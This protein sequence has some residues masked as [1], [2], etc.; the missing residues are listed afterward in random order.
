MAFVK[1]TYSNWPNEDGSFWRAQEVN[2]LEGRIESAFDE[3]GSGLDPD[4]EAALAGTDGTPSDTNRFVTESD[5][6]SHEQSTSA[7]GAVHDAGSGSSG[8]RY[9]SPGGTVG[10][11]SYA[12]AVGDDSRATNGGTTGLGAGTRTGTNG[13]AVGAQASAGSSGVAVG[14]SAAASGSGNPVAI[15]RDAEADAD[16]RIVLRANEVIQK[17]TSGG[18]VMVSTDGG[19]SFTDLVAD[20][21]ARLSDARTPTSHSHAI[22]DV[23]NLQSSLDGKAAASHS[24]APSAITGGTDGQVLT[25]VSGAATWAD[26]AGGGGGGPEWHYIGDPGEP[27]FDEDYGYTTG[28]LRYS[29]DADG[30]VTWEGAVSLDSSLDTYVLSSSTPVPI[31]FRPA[32]EVT[33]FQQWVRAGGTSS[34][35]LSVRLYITTGGAFLHSN[36]TDGE[37]QLGTNIP[38]HFSYPAA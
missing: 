14:R 28:W 24:H 27:V 21:D 32:S 9:A 29:K 19:T 1:R 18:E 13:T 35:L 15:G 7:H 34:S 23:T 33:V 31:G 38:I 11:G 30:W 5:L 25:K 10:A 4:T 36:T 6:D 8:Y 12:T 26:P 16:D 3:I 17:V 37:S 22:G 20:D 2:D